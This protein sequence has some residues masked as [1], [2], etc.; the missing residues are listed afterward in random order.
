MDSASSWSCVTK[1]VVILRRVCNTRSAH[2]AGHAPWRRGRR[3][4]RP[5]AARAAQWPG[6]GPARPAAAAAR[7]L[8]GYF[9]LRGQPQ[10]ELEARPDPAR[11]LAHTQPEGH[12]VQGRHV[13]E[14]AVALEDHAH[15][16]T[17]RRNARLVHPST[18]IRPDRRSR[19]RPGPV[20]R[21]SCHSRT[22]RG[23]PPTPRLEG[24]GE[25]VERLRGP[26]AAAQTRQLDGGPACSPAWACCRPQ[27]V[28][29]RLCSWSCILSCLR[30]PANTPQVERGDHHEHQ[31]GDHE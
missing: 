25:A 17:L 31:P 1:S 19:S 2:A 26:E 30:H 7:H 24:Q 22:V 27:P 21:S 16:P 3:A 6:R 20:A 29:V 10:L 12:V 23:A 4:A 15:V 13:R 5:A 18:I 28:A 9:A 8:V 11:H 14:E